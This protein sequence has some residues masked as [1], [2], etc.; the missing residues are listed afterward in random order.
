MK[1]MGYDRERAKAELLSFGHSDRTVGDVVKFIDGYD[2]A[3]GKVPEN[4]MP[5]EE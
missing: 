5:S 4:Y 1:H 3:T 2:P